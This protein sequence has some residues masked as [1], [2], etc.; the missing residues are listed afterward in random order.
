M[1]ISIYTVKE[2][3]TQIIMF[4][5]EGLETTVKTLTLKSGQNVH[6]PIVGHTYSKSVCLILF[7]G[8]NNM[9]KIQ[10]LRFLF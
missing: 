4:I 2:A 5:F 1:N 3:Q 7:S 8:F 6:F 9:P 10:R